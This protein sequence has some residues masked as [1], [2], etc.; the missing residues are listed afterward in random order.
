MQ[1]SPVS[2]DRLLV[3]GFAIVLSAT[4]HRAQESRMLRRFAATII[5]SLAGFA[6]VSC[7]IKGPLKLPPAKP[8]APASIPQTAPEATPEMPAPVS[9]PPAASAPPPAAPPVA[10]APVPGDRKP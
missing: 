4:E 5:V 3:D 1:S 10:P 8:G 9:S 6:I 2:R 7:G